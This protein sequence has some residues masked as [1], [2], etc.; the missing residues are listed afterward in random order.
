GFE[1]IFSQ[2]LEEFRYEEV[3]EFEQAYEVFWRTD[4]SEFVSPERTNEPS[5]RPGPVNISATERL[6]LPQPE[7][8]ETYQ[9]IAAGWEDNL[10]KKDFRRIDPVEAPEMAK[11]ITQLAR[12][13]AQRVCR[14]WRISK[15]T[16]QIDMRRTFRMM[17]RTGG[18]PADLRYR[19]KKVQKHRLTVFCDVSGSMK[20][21]TRFLLLFI[22][23][24]Q[25]HIK[26]TETFIFSTSLTRVTPLMR[27]TTFDQAMQKIS[28]QALNWSGGT[29]I[30]ASLAMFNRA[31]LQALVDR[32][33]T[34]VII[35]DGWDR[36]DRELLDGEL[37]LL[38]RRAGRIIWLNPLMGCPE[39]APECGGL[40]TA[41]PYLTHL[42]PFYNLQTLKE[43]GQ[44]LEHS[45]Y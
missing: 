4:I 29:N 44:L 17:V 33:T 2:T 20:M 3:A 27:G 18:F 26:N 36:G 9:P 30:G 32:K 7:S 10:V 23:S 45:F 39:Y 16:G 43:F 12:K 37:K 24:L 25:S 21:Y 38:H 13:I 11:I 8:A 41:L 14:R 15:K 5:P 1:V 6:P 31:Y 28:H 42:A 40:Q 19:E 34:V 22:H 35:S